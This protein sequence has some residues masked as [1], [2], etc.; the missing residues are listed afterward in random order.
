MKEKLLELKSVTKTFPGVI[1]LDNVDFRVY[2]GRIM[3]LAGENG[4]GKSTLMKVITGI[5]TKD[6]GEI[7]YKGKNINFSGITDSIEA[8]IGIIH[9]ELNLLP[10]LS[11]MENIFLGREIVNSI[12]KIDYK[13]MKMETLTI[14]QK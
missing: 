1:A 11:I 2:K 12:G 5:Y 6:K 9:Q 4:A 10:E 7:V 3:A 13:I 14:I 8:G